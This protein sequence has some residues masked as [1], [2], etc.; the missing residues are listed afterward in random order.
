MFALKDIFNQQFDVLSST[1][2]FPFEEIKRAYG[3]LLRFYTFT[4]SFPTNLYKLV[5]GRLDPAILI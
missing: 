1:E 5:L 4:K 3:Y 2:N